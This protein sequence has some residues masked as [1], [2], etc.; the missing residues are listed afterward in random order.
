MLKNLF[1]QR[2]FA[3]I[4]KAWPVLIV[5]GGIIPL[6]L[7]VMW[8]AMIQRLVAAMTWITV[9]LFDILIISVT[10]FFYLKGLTPLY[11]FI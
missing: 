10:V 1:L 2:Y 11:I 6:V 5:C 9:A 7:S 3:D 4:G 8:L